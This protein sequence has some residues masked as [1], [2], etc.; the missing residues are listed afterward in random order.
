MLYQLYMDY[1]YSNTNLKGIFEWVNITTLNIRLNIIYEK[2][3]SIDVLF[4]RYYQ[5]AKN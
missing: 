3:F 2:L 1:Y 5:S 4:I